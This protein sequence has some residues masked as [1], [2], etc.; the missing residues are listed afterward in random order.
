MLSSYEEVTESEPVIDA[1]EI[2]TILP[3]FT[4]FLYTMLILK[5]TD[6]VNGMS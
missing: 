1:R 2:K 6:T 3:H 5:R 4:G